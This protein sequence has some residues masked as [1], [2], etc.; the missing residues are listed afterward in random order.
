GTGSMTGCVYFTLFYRNVNPGEEGFSLIYPDGSPRPG[1]AALT[2]AFK[3]LGGAGRGKRLQLSP[4]LYMA[5][6]PAS[7]GRTLLVVWRKTGSEKLD[8]PVAFQSAFDVTGRPFTTGDSGVTA[9]PEVRYLYTDDPAWRKI[10]SAAPL[11]TRPGEP[12]SFDQDEKL[13]FSGAGFDAGADGRRRIAADAAPGRYLM[14]VAKAGKLVA[15][16]LIVEAN[17]EISGNHV[18]WPVNASNPEWQLDGILRGDSSVLSSLAARLDGRSCKIGF[19]PNIQRGDKFTA[20]IELPAQPPR[21]PMRLE[22][23]SPAVNG[24]STKRVFDVDYLTAKRGVESMTER[25]LAADFGFQGNEPAPKRIAA[26]DCAATVAVAYD[27][28]AF[29]VTVKVDDND[30]HQPWRERDIWQGDSIQLG[31]DVDGAKPVEAN[32][33]FGWNGHR[34]FEYGA[35]H[36]AD[37]ANMVWRYLAYDPILKENVREPKVGF[38][39]ERDGGSLC[40]KLR[41]PWETLGL[42]QAPA[43]GAVFGFSLIVNDVDQVS[44]KTGPRHGLRLFEGVH[45]EKD[46]RRFGKLFLR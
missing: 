23:T 15:R 12:I 44:G 35:A 21:L 39:F 42:K 26:S 6:F 31:I 28:A 13:L 7:L 3:H 4:E 18:V 9:T 22:L 2:A 29:Y 41:F 11:R 16:P 37:G 34:V 32:A 24:R 19:P 40:Y 36:D 17:F 46:P 30:F 10:V 33:Q 20:T 1:L 27:D 43:A 45:P 25:H 38:E 5:A 8:L 14:L